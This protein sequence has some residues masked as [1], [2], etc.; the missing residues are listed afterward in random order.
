M[1]FLCNYHGVE[2]KIILDISLGGKY[3]NLPVKISIENLAI[4]GRV[5]SIILFIKIFL[6]LL[7]ENRYQILSTITLYL[8][9]FLFF[10]SISI[11]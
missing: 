4:K 6:I 1:D 9:N 3:L 11:S 2:A 7:D 8:Y 10:C 5:Y